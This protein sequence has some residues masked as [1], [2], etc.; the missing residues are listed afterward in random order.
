M[1][2]I[3]HV[4]FD[5]DHTLWDFDSNSAETLT[6]LYH[7]HALQSHGVEDPKHFVAT[8]QEVNEEC[9]AEYRVGTMN[10]EELRSVRFHRTLIKYGVDEDELAEAFGDDYVQ[11]SPYKKGLIDGTIEVLE[12]LSQSYELHII[13]NGFE[14]VQHI[15]IQ[16]SGLRQYFGEVIT[17]EQAGFKKPAPGIFEYAAQKTNA[18]PEKSLMIGDGLDTDVLG[19]RKAGFHQ[20]FFNPQGLKHEE[21]PSHEIS[22]LREL[23]DIL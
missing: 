10:K 8:Y 9:W 2:D 22:H 12:Y 1:K 16:E 20:V 13:T 4:F 11:M 3:K 17:S 21:T 14:E 15:K 7:R 19:A 5:L 23:M 6:E 18:V